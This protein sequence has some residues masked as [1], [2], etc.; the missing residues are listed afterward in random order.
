MNLLVNAC[1]AIEANQLETLGTITVRTWA[2]EDN[3]FVAISDTGCGMSEEV[4]R[5]I[6]EPFYTTKEMGKGTGL[7]LSISHEIIKKHGGELTVVSEVG[8]GTTFTIRLPLN[9]P[10]SDSSPL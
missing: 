3:A 4:Q 2:D 7:G 5:R 1:H 8:A 10:V 6:F 9:R